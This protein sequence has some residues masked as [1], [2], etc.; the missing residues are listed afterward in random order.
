MKDIRCRNAIKVNG[1]RGALDGKRTLKY[2]PGGI[3]R[4][5]LLKDEITHFDV[6]IHTSLFTK[7]KQTPVLKINSWLSKGK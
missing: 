6:L 7:H 1:T 5:S 3:R 4:S 2:Y